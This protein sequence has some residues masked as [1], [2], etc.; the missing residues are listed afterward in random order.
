MTGPVL[1]RATR[2]PVLW[3][4]ASLSTGSLTGKGG[5][6]QKP[7]GAPSTFAFARRRGRVPP[8]F[9]D[10]KSGCDALFAG[11]RER[12]IQR[13]ACSWERSLDVVRKSAEQRLTVSTSAC[14]PVAITLAPSKMP[15][16]IPATR[17]L[18]PRAFL[19]LISNM[20]VSLRWRLAP[21]EVDRSR[22]YRE[23]RLQQAQMEIPGGFGLDS[24]PLFRAADARIR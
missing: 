24:R 20:F 14:A 22:L 11:G 10:K 7:C 17:R 12:H 18:R 5:W 16:R 13:Q 2:S 6:T 1:Q 19:S 3:D 9:F 8:C 23:H 4:R 15:E 21:A